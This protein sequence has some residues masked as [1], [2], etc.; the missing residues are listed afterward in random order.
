MSIEK[1]YIDCTH[2]VKDSGSQSGSGRVEKTY[3]DND[4]KGY[5]GQRVNHFTTVAGKPTTVT[6]YKFFSS[7]FTFKNGDLIVY[8]GDTYEVDSPPKNTAN[9]GHHCKI[10]LKRVEGVT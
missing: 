7:T 2:R 3:T 4:I 8:D 1:Y 6:R 5:I 9:K 10:F